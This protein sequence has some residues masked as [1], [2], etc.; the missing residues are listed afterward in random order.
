M[1]TETAAFAR[2]HVRQQPFL[3]I[4]GGDSKEHLRETTVRQKDVAGAGNVL[5]E[6]CVANNLLRQQLARDPAAEVAIAK[7]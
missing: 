1:H 5:V 2:R 7:N 4:D 6:V 3:L